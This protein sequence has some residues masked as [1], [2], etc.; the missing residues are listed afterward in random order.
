MELS[1]METCGG[2]AALKKIFSSTGIKEFYPPQTLALKA[3]LLETPDSFVVAAPTASGKTLIAEMAALKVFLEKAGRTV[4]L[5][6][7]RALAREKYED[8]S[9]KYQATGMRIVQSSGD[10]DR[11]EPWLVEGDL[12]IATN[13][14]MDSLIR[15]RAMWLKDIG[16][17]I[18]DE[19]HLLR[20][21]RRGP[22]LEIVLSRFRSMNPSLRVIALSA[23]IPNA[24]EISEWLG[25]RLVESDWRPVPLREGVYFNGAAIFNDGTVTW[26]SRKSGL[27]AVDLALETLGERG[28]ALIFVNTRRA[29]EAVARKSQEH[30][31]P[32][33]SGPEREWLKELSAQIMGVSHEPTR[34]CRRLAECA[35]DGVAFHH[36]GILSTQRKL[37]ED[38]F[39]TNRLKCIVATTTLAMGLNLPSRR[40]IIRDWWRYESGLGM[41]PIPAIEIKQMGG[42]A[43]RPGFDHYGEAVLIARSKGDEKFLFE[44]Y[45]KGKLERIDSQIGNEPALRT[46]V[47]A[48]VAGGFAKNKDELN[49]FLGRS[50]FAHQKGT[51]YLFRITAEI[52][53]FLEKEEMVVSEKGAL[54]ATLL[55]RRISELYIDPLTGVIFRD[56]HRMPKE[57][58]D[59]ALLHMIAQTPDMMTLSV[60]KKELEDLLE[61]FYKSEEMLLIPE[62]EKYP[63]D[64]MLSQIKT[65]S[66]LMQ[67]ILETPEDAIIGQF[68]IGPGDL[69]ALIEISDWLL[70]AA[71]EIGRLLKMKDTMKGLSRLRVRVRYGVREELL[72]LVSLRG[73]GRVRARNLYDSGFRSLK[74]IGA[75]TVEDLSRVPALGKN[76]AEDLKTQVEINESQAS[77]LKSRRKSNG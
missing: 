61:L 24:R 11:A 68:G 17:V 53:G 8:F 14:K 59:F 66:V 70:Y 32:L 76:L 45:I 10:Y 1:G 56:A 27:D 3:G 13:E 31:F 39:R 19:V 44:N 47:L 34:I 65:A 12:V 67:W 21:P 25:A 5:V 36:A 57:K 18:A 41:Q 43:G 29:S 54:K 38:A 40:V 20:D 2:S 4:Y 51:S 46:H 55:G 75:A 63:T 49:D 69:R 74:E 9:K 73:I 42:R 60:R 37:I 7:L 30:V 71:F 48:S 23:T 62:E 16:L 15:H 64:E 50:F 28:Q 26:V 33:L 77:R 72:E 6:P 22:T 58:E 35:S 52:L